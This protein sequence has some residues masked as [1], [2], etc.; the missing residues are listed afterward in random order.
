LF[1]KEHRRLKITMASDGRYRFGEE[2]SIA[3]A[4]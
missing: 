2:N 1:E 3:E 4:R